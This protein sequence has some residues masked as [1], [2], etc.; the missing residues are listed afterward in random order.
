MN[1]VHD[2]RR[3]SDGAEIRE[4]FSA[5]AL[6]LT[7]CSHLGAGGLCEHDTSG[8][9]RIHYAGILWLMGAGLAAWPVLV[10][11]G[12]RQAVFIIEWFQ[13][14]LFAYFWYLES[15]RLWEH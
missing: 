3:M 9:R 8:G 10:W 6:P 1:A 11:L 14:G 2:E 13:I 5:E 12:V 4:P 15:R 7:E